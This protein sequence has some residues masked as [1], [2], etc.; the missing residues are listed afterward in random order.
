[1]ARPS[2]SS[3]SDILKHNIP[4]PSLSPPPSYFATEERHGHRSASWGPHTLLSSLI[5]GAYLLANKDGMI[6]FKD[7]RV[8][9]TLDDVSS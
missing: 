2:L 3:V 7:S 8:R 4:L 1:M 9:I 5:Q 6:L